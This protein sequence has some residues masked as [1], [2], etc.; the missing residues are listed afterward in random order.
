LAFASTLYTKAYSTL[1][2]ATV[3]FLYLSYVMPAAAG[4]RA[5]GRSWTRMGPFDLGGGLY[6]AL[7][8]VALAG[9]ALLVWIGVQPPNEKALIVTL[10]AVG[11]LAATWWL[12][13]RRHFRGPP[14]MGPGD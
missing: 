7:A 12:G 1:T 4:L 8:V 5:Y 2:T 9:V 11:L 13:V 14:A 6:R 10:A 3:I